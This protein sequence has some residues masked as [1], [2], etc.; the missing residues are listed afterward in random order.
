MMLQ[1]DGS[2]LSESDE[3][4]D[5][6]DMPPLMEDDDSEQFVELVVKRYL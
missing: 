3:E 1:D 6:K 4:D 5:C 2:Y